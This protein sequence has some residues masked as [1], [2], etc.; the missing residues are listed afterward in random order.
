MKTLKANNKQEQLLLAINYALVAFAI[1]C[2]SIA[3]VQTL[4]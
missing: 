3:I 1:L 4:F 2:T